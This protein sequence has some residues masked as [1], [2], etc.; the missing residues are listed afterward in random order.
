MWKRLKRWWSKD[1]S[2]DGWPDP[3]ESEGPSLMAASRAS[4]ATAEVEPVEQVEDPLVLAL[5]QFDS[6]LAELG[7][8]AAVAGIREL[9]RA[10]PTDPRVL[11]RAAAL[12]RELG[13]EALASGFEQ[14]ATSSS[15]LPLA[16]LAHTFLSMDDPELALALGDGAVERARAKSR[17]GA[18]EGDGGREGRLVGA[19]ALSRMGLHRE[20][21]ERLDPVID[22]DRVGPEERVRWALASILLGDVVA[23]GRVAAALEAGD[24]ADRWIA[25]V[26]ARARAFGDDHDSEDDADEPDPQHLLFT[27]YGTLLLD[28]A[29]EGETLTPERVARWMMA[30][31][32]LVRRWLPAGTRPV[33]VSP[34]GEVLARWLGSYLGSEGAMPLSAR[35][36]RQPVL[37]VLADDADLG[38]LFENRAF[39]EGPLP[40]F[41]AVKDPTEVGSPIADVVGVFRG[42]VA[43]PLDG[44]EAEKV[45]DRLPPR[46][47]VAR[48][49]DEVKRAGKVPSDELEGFF[50]W[51]EA[52]RALASLANPPDPDQRIPLDLAR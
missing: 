8:E 1:P 48:L 22:S 36:P 30:L 19:L 41:Q 50:G 20:V 28:D 38:L 16:E 7:P 14:A 43:L 11:R 45:A 35:I 10:G 46:L 2:E 12:L 24:A 6:E 37:V 32:V 31:S 17:R 21:L 13:D 34:R 9:V 52:R 44:L 5:E 49:Q 51:A 18:G 25:E 3:S 23:F 39:G 40:I 42:G 33:W 15:G 26:V 29:G 47:V 27:L 4:E